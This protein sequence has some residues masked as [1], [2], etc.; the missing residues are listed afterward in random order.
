MYFLRKYM[1]FEK[2]IRRKH[3]DN[4]GKLLLVLSLMW[5]YINA[6][7]LFNGWYSGESVQIEALEY[8]LFGPY[9]LLYWAMIAFCAFAP[10]LLISGRFRRSL[11]PM[12]ILSIAINIG[13]KAATVVAVPLS[14]DGPRCPCASGQSGPIPWGWMRP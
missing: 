6:L 13:I 14:I 1:N 11:V 8:K 12:L 10:L 3:F 4:L 9:G 2:Y 7:E 5:T